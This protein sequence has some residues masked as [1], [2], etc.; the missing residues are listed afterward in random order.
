M[1]TSTAMRNERPSVYDIITDRLVA[2]LEKGV[3]PWRRDWDA[4][5]FQSPRNLTSGQMYKGINFFL[6]AM[7]STQFS[8]PYWL[9]FRQA[10]ARGGAVKKGE[11]GTPVF[12]WKVYEKKSDRSGRKADG[13]ETDDKRF[14]ARYYTVFNVEQCDG[15]DYPK[16]VRT[17][18]VVPPIASC[19]TIVASYKDAPALRHGGGAAFYSPIGDVVQM[20]DRDRF[21]SAEE[22]YCTLFHEL[23]HS[24]GHPN[25]LARLSF[26][27]S[28]APF[29]SA[30]YSKE[31]LL[32]EMGAAFL[33]AQAGIS[34][35]TIDNSA[36]YIGGWLRSFKDDKR[37][38]AFAAAGARKAAEWIVGSD[39]GLEAID[40]RGEEATAS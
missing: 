6:L 1:K 29:G 3:V 19:D 40:D 4:D 13:D 36:A 11:K 37:L 27:S 35:A 31:E 24:T 38:V 2:A 14:V 7:M 15:I 18:R 12:F 10:L 5:S 30:D 33:C 16:P 9:T 22:Y 20:P 25:R 28:P 17:P 8:S 39:A 34:N 32:A 21:S 23:C 26:E